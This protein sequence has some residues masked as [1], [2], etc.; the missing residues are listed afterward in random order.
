MSQCTAI[1]DKGRRCRNISMRSIRVHQA[2]DHPQIATGWFQV[3]LCD[4]CF[5]KSSANAIVTMKGRK[6]WKWL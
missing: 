4:S 3:E 5:F 6:N 1:N 2:P